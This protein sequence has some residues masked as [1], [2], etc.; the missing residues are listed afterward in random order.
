MVDAVSSAVRAHLEGE[1]DRVRGQLRE[2]HADDDSF[3][4]GFADTSQVTAERGEIE[5]LSASL[6]ETLHDLDDA[7]VKLDAGT[8]GECERCGAEIGDAR[9][10]AMPA[11]RLCIA[12]ASNKR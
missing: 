6:T 12:C 1:R 5:A 3:D 10:E 8:Y 4:E 2:L 7:L 9:L 11:A